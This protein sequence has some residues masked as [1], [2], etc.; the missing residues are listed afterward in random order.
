MGAASPALAQERA[1]VGG[2]YV[3]VVLGYDEVSF[4]DGVDSGGTGD[5]MYGVTAGYDVG[6][7][8]SGFFGAEVEAAESQVAITVSDVLTVGDSFTLGAGRDLYV[9]AR[10][11]LA[12]GGRTQVYVKA[13]Y[14]NLKMNAEYDDGTTV[15]ADSDSL[16][17]VRVGAGVEIGVGAV[18]LRGEYRYSKYGEVLDSG[19]D[20]T[21][22]Q[23]V[24]AAVGRF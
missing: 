23:L 19:V 7:G 15:I 22:H 17:G 18:A 9:G 12:V 4:D 3:G 2:G 11:G 13:G 6:F 8:G 1:S 5:L 20:L 10:V 14:T 24:A 21:R 16:D